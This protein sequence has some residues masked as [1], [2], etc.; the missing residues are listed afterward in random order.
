M[1]FEKLQQDI[2]KLAKQMSHFNII[3]EWLMENGVTKE[4][5]NE[6]VIEVNYVKVG[7]PYPGEE[8]TLYKKGKFD[9]DLLEFIARRTFVTKYIF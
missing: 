8:I 2:N 5:A 7:E 1:D 4:N 6:Y 3:D 9:D